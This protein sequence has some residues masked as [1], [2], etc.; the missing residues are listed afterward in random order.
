MNESNVEIKPIFLIGY[1]PKEII[2]NKDHGP[3]K[4]PNPCIKCVTDDSMRWSPKFTAGCMTLVLDAFMNLVPDSMQIEFEKE[5]LRILELA[6]KSRH[7]YIFE[8]K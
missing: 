2:L 6:I 1:I 5:T 3:V 4:I 7:N 8:P